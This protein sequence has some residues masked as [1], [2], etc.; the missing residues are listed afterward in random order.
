MLRGYDEAVLGARL[1]RRVA[2]EYDERLYQ[3]VVCSIVETTTTPVTT[4][5]M[6]AICEVAGVRIS[7]AD[8]GR[9]AARVQTRIA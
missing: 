3:E 9:V 8:V 2:E 5:V 7:R 4:R 1:C 6:D